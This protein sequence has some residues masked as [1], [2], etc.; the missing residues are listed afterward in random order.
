MSLAKP[1]SAWRYSTITT[2][3][4]VLGGLLGYVIGMLFITELTPYLKYL[5]YAPQIAQATS[6]FNT[7]GF[8][9]LFVAAFTPLPFKVFT[10][11]AGAGSMPILPFVLGSLVGRGL[12]FYIE[13]GLIYW[14][15]RRMELWI[16]KSIDWL[17]WL[18][19]VIVATVIIIY[20]WH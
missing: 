16:R 20:K 9:V 4:S 17:G 5:G 1:E 6:W 10:I 15:G 2:L 18:M 12:R 8:W 19:L 7:W 13:A 14:G 3:M 11:A